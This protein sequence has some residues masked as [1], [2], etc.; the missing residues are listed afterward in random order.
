MAMVPAGKFRV[1]EASLGKLD[2]HGNKPDEVG[3]NDI[4]LEVSGNWH[5]TMYPEMYGIPESLMTLHAQTISLVNEKHKLELAALSD[6][7]IAIALKKHIKTLEQQIWTWEQTKLMGPDKPP[8]MLLVTADSPSQ[9]KPDFSPLAL[10]IKQALIIYFYRRVY[11]MS[12]MIMQDEVRKT[13]DYIQPYL[14]IGKYDQDFAITIGWV[15]FLAAC[16][17]S[18]PDLQ[19]RSLE[20]LEII[21][22][23]GVFV[24]T[25]KPSKT[26][27]AVWQR[28]EE[29]G[30]LSFGWPDLM[31]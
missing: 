8:H 1:T 7:S 13:L 17:A 25:S 9:P 27:K 14:E 19:K 26:A 22:N 2:S 11:N 5:M 24:E 18:V 6:P 21:D 16:E 15:L 28:R 29:S 31:V 12:A 10:A 4:H 20:C 3:Y 30:D 23:C